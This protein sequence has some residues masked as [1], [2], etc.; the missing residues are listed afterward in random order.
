VARAKAELFLA[1]PSGSPSSLTLSSSFSIPSTLT[2]RPSDYEALRDVGAFQAPAQK[3]HKD[4]AVE[5]GAVKNFCCTPHTSAM[6]A[7]IT[8]TLQV[9]QRVAAAGG[10]VNEL[11][12]DEP[13][14]AGTSSPECGGPD[15]GPTLN[16]L[17]GRGLGHVSAGRR[18]M[19][20]RTTT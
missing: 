19:R 10:Q 8:E 7:S 9:V 5:V 13:F 6:R 2:P 11:A 18:Q 12:M 15:V 14:L 17:Q 16:C 20:Q 3:C 1:Q 4:I